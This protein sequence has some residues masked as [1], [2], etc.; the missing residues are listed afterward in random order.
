MQNSLVPYEQAAI[1]D[2][3]RLANIV[4]GL[5]NE[6]F[7]EGLDF[8]KIPGTGDKPTLLQPGMEKLC[9]ALHLRPEYVEKS[10]I[11]D[12]DKPLIYYR[13]EC[14]LIDY[15]TGL[16]ISTAIGSA[17]SHETKW[18]YRASERVCPNCGKDT[19]KKS[20]FPPK[21]APEGTQAGWYCYAKIGGCGA[22]FAAN[23]PAIMDQQVGRIENPDIFDQMNT[24]DK[25]A[26]K[27]ALGSAVKGA[28]NV[29]ELFTVDM[30]DFV[31]YD[32]TS[33]IEGTYTVVEPP[34]VP[35]EA[36][37]TTK[38]DAFAES[39]PAASKWTKAMLHDAT[40]DYF[41]GLEHFANH[42]LKH[43]REYDGLTLEEASA[44][45]RASHWNYDRDVVKALFDWADKT[46]KM[47]V[48]NVMSALGIKK[49]RDWERGSYAEAQDACTVWA[50]NVAQAD[51]AKEGVS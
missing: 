12:F 9:R 21:G 51:L 34:P 45:V 11:E 10:K 26:Q 13:Y 38:P 15:E 32:T 43:E 41:D 1:E 19:I 27:R 2:V 16:C 23:A 37:T 22:E 28:A 39:F 40:H 25:I 6:V 8:G 36:G 5:R 33:V 18:R 20:K 42:W 24:I 29:S 48:G 49:M 3:K 44:L 46:L 35:K 31:P 7:K 4:L 14:R 50:E 17:N 47:D 30:E